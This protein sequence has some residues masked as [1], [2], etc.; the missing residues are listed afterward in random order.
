MTYQLAGT[1][2]AFRGSDPASPVNS[3]FNPGGLPAMDMYGG[4]GTYYRCDN[5]HSFY[6]P[7]RDLRYLP[8]SIQRRQ[9]HQ[10]QLACGTS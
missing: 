5:A 10:R 3:I 7:R 2:F 4:N 8:V 1:N 6:Q 9:L